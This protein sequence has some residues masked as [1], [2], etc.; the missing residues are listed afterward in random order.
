MFQFDGRST[1]DTVKGLAVTGEVEILEAG[2]S[3]GMFEDHWKSVPDSV[4]GYLF[5]MDDESRARDPGIALTLYCLPGAMDYVF[6]AFQVAAQSRD[7][8]L[9]IELVLD[10]PNNTGEDFWREA[11][12]KEWLRVCSWKLFSGA[13][14]VKSM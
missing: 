4:E 7:G 8:G 12:R 3:L 2:E 1:T 9:G 13:Q 6:K 14:L 5:L 10:C 11:W